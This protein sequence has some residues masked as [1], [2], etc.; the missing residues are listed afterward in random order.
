MDGI[1]KK[2]SA[3]NKQDEFQNLPV[4][5]ITTVAYCSVF[6]RSEEKQ[7]AINTEKKTPLSFIGKDVLSLAFG[8]DARRKEMVMQS[9]PRPA[10]FGDHGPIPQECVGVVN[11][12][13]PSKHGEEK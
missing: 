12:M 10:D 4:E 5:R 1:V 6:E 3:S 9:G 8:R 2:S 11:V 13:A 7:K